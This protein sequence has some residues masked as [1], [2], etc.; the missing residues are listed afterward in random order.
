MRLY[1]FHSTESC[2]QVYIV[3]ALKLSE[4]AIDVV[5]LR[6]LHKGHNELC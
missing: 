5:G 1:N 3:S 2:L 4:T 6:E